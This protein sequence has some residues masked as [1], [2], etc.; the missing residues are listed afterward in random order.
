VARR[1]TYQRDRFRVYDLVGA[2]WG[3][4]GIYPT[5]EAA[6]AAADKLNEADR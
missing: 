1:D 3:D 5:R 2:G 6:Q 4:D